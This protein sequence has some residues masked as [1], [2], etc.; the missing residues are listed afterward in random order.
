MI[1]QPARCSWMVRLQAPP[2]REGFET[3]SAKGGAHTAATR[4][5]YISPVDT[6]TYSHAQHGTYSVAAAIGER[7]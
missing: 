6:Y 3:A 7:Q 5:L 4:G 2:Q 1:T